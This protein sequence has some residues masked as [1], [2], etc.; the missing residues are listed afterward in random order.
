[1]KRIIKS[2]GVL[3]SCLIIAG[4]P[5]IGVT[6]VSANDVQTAGRSVEEFL[7][8]DGSFDLE[9]A[10]LSGY[11]GSLD[12]DGLDSQ[13]DPV[14]GEPILWSSAAVMAVDH[15]DDIYWDN[16]I[17]PSI[18]GVSDGAYA[19]TVYN[20]KLIVGGYFQVVDDV[21]A[22]YVASWDGNSWSPQGSGMGGDGP[23]IQTLTV[24]DGNLIAGGNFDTAGGVAANTI[25]SWNGSSWSPM[26]S[27]LGREEWQPI[28][29][30]LT[31]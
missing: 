5:A 1:M 27:G 31:V 19:A 29:R 25:A 11:Q 28:V 7:N 13:F 3:A 22:N 2:C 21:V 16:S 23:L 10:R 6:S 20:G 9:A 12:L 24:Y 18:A 17:S 4:L 30:A 26:G 14:T 8:P 15:P